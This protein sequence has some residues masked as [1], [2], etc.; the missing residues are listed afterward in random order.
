MGRERREKLYSQVTD[1]L[2]QGPANTHQIAQKTGINWQ[3]V[4]TILSSLVAAGLAENNNGTYRLTGPIT[5]NPKTILGLPITDEQEHILTSIAQRIQQLSSTRMNRTFLQKTLVQT[6]KLANIDTVPY[7]WYLFGECTILILTDDAIANATH[8]TQYDTAIRQAIA[9]MQQFKTTTELMGDQYR[10]NSLYRC[11]LTI[12][13]CFKSVFTPS[14]LDIIDEQLANIIVDIPREDTEAI[15]AAK[16][17]YS[18]FGRLSVLGIDEL[19]HLR[20]EIYTLFKTL[21]ELIASLNFYLCV[22]HTFKEDITP[23]YALKKESLMTSLGTY[24]N[25][26][27]AYCPAP[28]PI[29]PELR[30][31]KGAQAI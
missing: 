11:R 13:K 4:N 19:E 5:F 29:D 17:V 3:S 20:M 7:G 27:E 23:Y 1:T 16:A 12:D 30:R 10:N 31:F 14:T 22:R 18:L 9:T 8:T 21:W 15:E 26:L 25:H 6:L 28:K 2:R 24:Y